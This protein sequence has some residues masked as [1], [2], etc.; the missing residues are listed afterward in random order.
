MVSHSLIFLL[1]AISGMSDDQVYQRGDRDQA[2]VRLTG[3]ASAAAHSVEARVLR[4]YYALPGLDWTRVAEPRSGQWEGSLS[5]PTGGPYRVEFRWLDGAGKTIESASRSGVLVGDL[6]ILAGQSNMQ[7]VGNLTD[8]EPPNGQVHMFDMSDNWRLAEEPLHSLADAVDSVH[9]R[10]KPRLTGAEAADAAR[11]RTKG[12]GLGLPFATAMLRFTGVPVGLVP[13]AHGG[14]SMEQWSPGLRDQGG[15]SLYGAMVRR[16]QTVGGR[17]KGVLWYQG[18]AEANPKRLPAY[19]ERMKALV[20]SIRTDFRQPDL[21]FYYVQIGRVIRLGDPDPWNA[22]QDLQQKL[23][24]EIPHTGMVAGIDLALDDL[25]HVGTPG[26]K[27]LGLR[28]AQL[29]TGRTLRGPRIV[30]ARIE[31]P[32]RRRIRVTFR[33]VNGRLVSPGRPTGFSLQIPADAKDPQHFNTL[34]EGDSVVLLVQ[35]DVPGGTTLWYGRGLDPYANLTD[36]KN[37]ALPVTGPVPI[38]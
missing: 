11:R 30:S 14:T 20:Q 28:L 32:D 21:P 17:V 8:V 15:A 33:D 6:W 34:L 9:W 1:A 25:I 2:Q 7:G 24:A 37:M 3:T 26:L 27:V 35:S 29:A 4:Q 10:G 36:E 18:E 38:E 19:A 23:E 5:L 16:H 13:C 31:G 12:A 22:V